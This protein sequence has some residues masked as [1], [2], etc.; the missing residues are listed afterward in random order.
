ML[1][2]KSF[3]QNNEITERNR[4]HVAWSPLGR[5]QTLMS[6]C[7]LLRR[8]LF[9][10]SRIQTEPSE[11]RAVFWDLFKLDFCSEV[12]D[13]GHTDKQMLKGRSA[14]FRWFPP[15]I[16]FHIRELSHKSQ[17]SYRYF[18]YLT[19][20][21]GADWWERAKAISYQSCSRLQQSPLGRR[22]I[23]PCRVPSC[24]SCWRNRRA[25]SPLPRTPA[26]TGTSRSGTAPGPSSRWDI[27]RP[28]S[29][30]RWRTP[31]THTPRRYTTRG[32]SSLRGSAALSSCPLRSRGR[33]RTPPPRRRPGPSSR[34]GS[35][36]PS[37]FCRSSRP[38]R[39]SRT[40][41]SW[42]CRG[43]RSPGQSPIGLD[44]NDEQSIICLGDVFSLS[45]ENSP[46]Q[47]DLEEIGFSF[48]LTKE[49]AFYVSTCISISRRL[50]AAPLKGGKKHL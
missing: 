37:S 44:K 15:R 22:R 46:K 14:V 50:T 8:N 1:V 18:L 12:L 49:K 13:P 27:S 32:L 10:C 43:R 33:T 17:R 29:P 23:L 24:Y 28:C 4:A 36:A 25:S 5:R 20:A 21:R 3:W 41:R 11:V 6:A 40:G 35:A 45:E 2:S 31:R 30:R 38:R 19:T 7:L 42:S 16:D 39:R 9:S 26:G 48:S 34:P 47:S